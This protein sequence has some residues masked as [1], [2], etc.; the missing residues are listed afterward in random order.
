M[1]MSTDEAAAASL[2]PAPAAPK[3]GHTAL[4]W[5]VIVAAVSF[6]VGS[7]YV[8]LSAAKAENA[9]QGEERLNLV[10][11]ELQFRYFVG[12]NAMREQYPVLATIGG[13]SS[14]EIYAQAKEL[15]PGG[16][17][18]QL[19]LV[20]IAGELRGPAEALR[21]LGE[22]SPPLPAA[23]QQLV[24]ILTHVYRDDE[25]GHFD[26]P[27]LAAPRRALLAEK[28]GWFGALALH[29]PAPAPHPEAPGRAEVLQPA[30]RTY[31]TCTV[32]S[33]LILVAV[34]AGC[35]G[36]LAFLIW[37]YKSGLREGL[38]RGAGNYGGLYAETFACWLVC[39]FGLSLLSGLVLQGAPLLVQAGLA[40]LLSLVALA[41]PV[42]RGIP[43]QQ[44]RQ[45]I[46]W[47]GGR[48]H[49]LLELGA[50][51]VSYLVNLPVVRVGLAL[52]LTLATLATR[53][54]AGEPGDEGGAAPTPAHPLIQLLIEPS[55][56]SL[57]MIF[58]VA[59]IVAPFVEETMFR[60][61]L[62][63]HLRELTARL[64]RWPSALIGALVNSFI[65]A[66][67]HPQGLIAVPVLMSLALGFC[68]A[69][70][71]RGTLLSSIFAHGLNNALVTT[72]ALLALGR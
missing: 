20:P 21:L 35:F 14:E 30:V 15:T 62:Y 36:L 56:P 68:L 9:A 45:D 11:L 38:H 58:L 72:F 28:L 52:T 16:V 57:L 65:F 34:A 23:Q 31:L 66:V 42:L 27:S 26:L 32:A 37:A 6:L 40:M 46:G 19:R 53:L 3:K 10:V 29:A 50:G 2:G 71:W 70:E 17:E 18:A 44:V 5:L 4:A 61:V 22:I 51:A 59:S 48:R 64:G 67:I 33:L 49:P 24:D 8:P 69:R 55:W 7:R 13:A 54:A 39:Y 41:W 60:G 43:W 47:T 63:R 25:A 12:L 1:A